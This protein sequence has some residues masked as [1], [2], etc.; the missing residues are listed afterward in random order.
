MIKSVNLACAPVS[1][2]VFQRPADRLLRCNADLCLFA[3]LFVKRSANEAF[4]SF[5]MRP[6]PFLPPL[7]GPTLF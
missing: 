4:E 5:C 7:S 1:I 6:A 2:R 3:G